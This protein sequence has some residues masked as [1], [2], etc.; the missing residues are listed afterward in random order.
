MS[1]QMPYALP[2][3]R[4]QYIDLVKK[5]RRIPKWLPPLCFTAIFLGV[6]FPFA[7]AAGLL[8]GALRKKD[9]KNLDEFYQQHVVPMCLAQVFG[10]YEYSHA[11]SINQWEVQQSGLVQMGRK[12]FEGDTFISAQYRGMTMMMSNLT[13]KGKGNDDDDVTFKGPFAVFYTLRQLPGRMWVF[14]RGG[15]IPKGD[16]GIKVGTGTAEFDRRYVV[17]AD[18][19]LMASAVLDFRT[20][21]AI[22]DAE[23]KLPGHIRF[24]LLDGKLIMAVEGGEPLLSRAVP[25]EGKEPADIDDLISRAMFEVC[26]LV[27]IADAMCFDD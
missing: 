10:S 25:K 21:N 6:P 19:P 22:M 16:H 9:E 1:T 17:Y 7:V 18:D 14:E 26:T 23:A 27:D 4:Q 24:A 15:H 5:S 11:G 13:T 2:A 8:L 12:S 20:M 3:V